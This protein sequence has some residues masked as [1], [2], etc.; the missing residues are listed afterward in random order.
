VQTVPFAIVDGQL[1]AS[2][3]FVLVEMLLMLTGP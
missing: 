1:S 2:L 3:K